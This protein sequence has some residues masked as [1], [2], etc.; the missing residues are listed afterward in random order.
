MINDGGVW[1][2]TQ[3]LEL[4]LNGHKSGE[5]ELR[6]EARNGLPNRAVPSHDPLLTNSAR[7]AV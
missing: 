5:E 6:V 4:I 1:N 2:R 7:D 3:S